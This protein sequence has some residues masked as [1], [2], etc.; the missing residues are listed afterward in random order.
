MT[1]EKAAEI[2]R[3]VAGVTDESDDQFLAGM[4]LLAASEVGTKIRACAKFIGVREARLRD[5]RNRLQ[6]SGVWT[7]GGIAHSGWFD[8]ESGG[9]AFCMD[10]AIGVGWLSRAKGR[11]PIDAKKCRPPTKAKRLIE[12]AA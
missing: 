10:V 12:G 7:P 1:R 4:L 3:D 5:I 2:V 9:I 6:A 11:R 8:E